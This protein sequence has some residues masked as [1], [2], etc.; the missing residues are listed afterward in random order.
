MKTK[1]VNYKVS[2]YL[3]D[4]KTSYRLR[5]WYTKEISLNQISSQV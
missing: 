3:I 1:N 2:V 5:F 4:E